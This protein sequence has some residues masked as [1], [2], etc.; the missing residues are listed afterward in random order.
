MHLWFL[1]VFTRNMAG[2]I[3]FAD[4]VYCGHARGLGNRGGQGRKGPKGHF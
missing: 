1:F 4:I 3:L 2:G